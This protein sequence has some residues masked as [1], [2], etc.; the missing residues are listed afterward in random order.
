[1]SPAWGESVPPG[2]D[3]Q[4]AQRVPPARE[5]GLL[6]VEVDPARGHALEEPHAVVLPLR[7]D[8]VDGL[9]QPGIGASGLPE[10]VEGPQHVVLPVVREGELEVPRVDDLAVRLAAEEVAFEEVLLARL[11]GA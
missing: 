1:S 7:P 5:A 4:G 6:E 10:V 11:S 9:G 8:D 3:P 2:E